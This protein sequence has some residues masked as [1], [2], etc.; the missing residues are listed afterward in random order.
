MAIRADYKNSGVSWTLLDYVAR[1]AKARDV[2]ILT[3]RSRSS[4]R[5]R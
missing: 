1:H 2:T 3:V 4:N 5:N